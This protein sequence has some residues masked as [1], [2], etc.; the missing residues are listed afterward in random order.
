MDEPRIK[1]GLF[2]DYLSPSMRMPAGKCS[3]GGYNMYMEWKVQSSRM[4][5][6]TTDTSL[7]V[8]YTARIKREPAV[9]AQIHGPAHPAAAH[10]RILYLI[11]VVLDIRARHPVD[12]VPI[13]AC[14]HGGASFV[15]AV[16]EPVRRVLRV[17]SV[18]VE[19]IDRHLAG[20]ALDIAA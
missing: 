12:R 17:N 6:N 2:C 16:I 11:E 8:N 13:T 9:V 20:I 1:A 19:S 3:P 5:A 15:I 18:R 10:G 14:E 7:T 4:T